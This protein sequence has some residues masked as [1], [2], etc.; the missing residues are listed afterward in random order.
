M[1]VAIADAQVEC[2]DK[3]SKQ[4]YLLRSSPSGALHGELPDSDYEVAISHPDFGSKITS[5]LKTSSAAPAQFRLLSKKITGYIWPKWSQSGEKAEIR[6][7]SH[8]IVDAS[9]WRM[10][11]EVEHIR[12]IGRFEPFAPKGDSQTLPDGDV[13]QI[14]AKWNHARFQYSPDLDARTLIAPDRSGLYYI[15]LKALNGETFTFPWIVAPKLPSAKVAVLTSNICWNAYNDWGGRSNYVA[16]DKLPSAPAVSTTQNSP[17]F[18]P[19]GA[20]WWVN[21]VFEPL[22]FDRPEPINN[23]DLTEKITEPIKKIG[24]EHLVAGEWRLLGW[25]EREKLEYDLYSENQF[26][27]GVLELQDYEVLV[28]STHPEYWTIN[29]YEKLKR[30]VGAGGRLLYLGGN[31]INCSVDLHDDA[32]TVFDMDLSEWLPQRAY[33]GAGALI[34]SRFGL[35][36]E[37]ESTLLGVVMSFA[38]MGTGAPYAVTDAAHPIFSGTGLSNGDEFG[39]ETLALRC[40]GGAS[41]HETDKMDAFSPVG[42]TLLAQGKNGPGAGADLV[43]Y[44]NSQGG[45]VISV[46]SINWVAGLPIDAML[47]AITR[48]MFTLALD[49]NR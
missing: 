19:T 10:G 26:D 36:H 8:E 15:Q 37:V 5:F 35:R 9:L 49:K 42:T 48:N 25:M 7:S 3:K 39:F 12:D 13:S 43:T 47:S 38:G 41:G 28:L 16:A 4:I 20:I 2:V 32:M 29:M 11:W 18:R 45:L 14:G 46:G 44:R 40:P 1:Y 17:W 6:F 33:S 23:L 30:W 24:S 27:S 31:G 21:D 22:S 34:P